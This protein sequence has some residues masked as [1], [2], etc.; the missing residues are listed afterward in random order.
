[1]KI[2][3]P[4]LHSIGFQTVHGVQ[5]CPGSTGVVCER[6][7]QRGWSRRAPTP[8]GPGPDAAFSYFDHDGHLRT[9]RARVTAA[10]TSED[11]GDGRSPHVKTDCTGEY[12]QYC[13]AAAIA[14][15]E[16]ES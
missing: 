4:H 6:R 13:S 10:R 1:V 15:G 3:I 7:T 9:V 12:K 5:V 16:L 2:H 8:K 11:V 14:D